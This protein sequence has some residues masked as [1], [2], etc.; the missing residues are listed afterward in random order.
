[1]T[2][3]PEK[4]GLQDVSPRRK[5]EEELIN[6]GWKRVRLGVWEAWA[7][8]QSQRSFTWPGKALFD[9][10]RE[11][12]STLLHVRRFLSD[13][14]ALGPRVVVAVWI[15]G[16]M[17]SLFP[18]LS[19]YYSNK[20]LST[21]SIPFVVL[22]A[23]THTPPSDRRRS[24]VRENRRPCRPATSRKLAYSEDSRQCALM[25]RVFLSNDC[26]KSCEDSFRGA[27]NYR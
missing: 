27:W 17:D 6:D 21:V 14:Y 18:G 1:M 7:A 15:L 10:I 24:H 12:R 8:T 26:P 22:S 9:Q 19:V 16:F 11:L 3:T 13:V 4:K 20:L 25:G 2:P 23:P 5:A